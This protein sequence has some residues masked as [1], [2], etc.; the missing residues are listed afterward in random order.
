MRMHRPKLK[1]PH[2]LTLLAVAMIWPLCATMLTTATAPADHEIAK[3]AAA[4]Q[5]VEVQAD[6][7][8]QRVTTVPERIR[9][10]FHNDR[11]S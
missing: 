11:A 10:H 5:V 8:W 4:M 6:K 2:P 7:F 9:A 3:G 1:M